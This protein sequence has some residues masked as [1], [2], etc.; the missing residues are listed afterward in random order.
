M[1]LPLPPPDADTSPFGLVSVCGLLTELEDVG[2]VVALVGYGHEARRLPFL[3]TSLARDDELLVATRTAVYGPLKRT[4]LMYAARTGDVRRVTALLRPRGAK[5]E[6]DAT[7]AELLT[8]LHHASASGRVETVSL[9]LAKEAY[10][11]AMDFY[12]RW[13]PLHYASAMGHAGVVALLLGGDAATEEMLV[14]DEDEDEDEDEEWEPCEEEPLHVACEHGHVEVVHLLLDK[15][16]DVDAEADGRWR[17]L[18]YASVMGHAGVAHLL[19]GRGAATDVVHDEDE[20]PTEQPLHV[21]CATGHIE[22]VRLLLDAGANE[23]AWDDDRCTPYMR[24]VQRGQEAVVTLLLN[25]GQH[26]DGTTN[27]PDDMPHT[28]LSAAVWYE[29]ELMA[30][31]LLDKGANVNEVDAFEGTLLHL[32]AW[33]GSVALTRL[34]LDRGADPKARDN[35]GKTPLDVA[36]QQLDRATESV[37]VDPREVQKYSD[38]IGILEALDERPATEE[39]VGSKM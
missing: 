22:V 13:R 9:L 2:R 38:V 21:A 18:H 34:F 26:V 3:C 12:G 39:G 4:R 28:A 20:E 15:D 30:R 17:P 11:D 19:L 6:V 27:G 10:V 23:S 24:A 25:R 31:L 1:D 35:E 5:H 16:A 33:S 29:Q 8:A 7:D 32:S 37:P 36:R 14:E